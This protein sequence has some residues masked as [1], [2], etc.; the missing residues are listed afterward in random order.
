MRSVFMKTTL[1]RFVL[2]LLKI[3]TMLERYQDVAVVEAKTREKR[4]NKRSEF[5]LPTS[6]RGKVFNEEVKSIIANNNNSSSNI[7]LG[8]TISEKEYSYR[9]LLVTGSGYTRPSAIQERLEKLYMA[10]QI[11]ELQ[12]ELEATKGLLEDIFV[13]ANSLKVGDPSGDN[14]ADE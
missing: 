6:Q 13:E 5:A 4:L 2:K 3:K 1:R 9:R 11:Q 14:T 7:N 8:D 10:E 12:K